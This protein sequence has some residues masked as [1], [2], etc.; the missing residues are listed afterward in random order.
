VDITVIVIPPLQTEAISQRQINRADLDTYQTLV[1]GHLEPLRLDRPPANMYLD[2]E[3]K[4]IGLPLNLRATQLAWAHNELFRGR[5]LIV[6]PA[7]L[8][9]PVTPQGYDTTVPRQ[10]VDELLPEGPWRVEVL[11]LGEARWATNSVEY[12]SRESA[13]AAAQDLRCR[14]AVAEKLRVVP[15][16]TPRNQSYEKFSEHI[17]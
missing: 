11:A 13:F 14:W 9:G 16:V 17:G 3:G 12:P 2:E 6:G 8:T 4:L 10:Y 1:E 15:T 5:D 7:F